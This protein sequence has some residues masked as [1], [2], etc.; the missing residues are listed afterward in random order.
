MPRVAVLTPQQFGLLQTLRAT[1]G[2]VAELL[3]GFPAEARHWSPLPEDWTAPQVVTH[4]AAADALFEQRFRRILGE[5]NPTVAYFD[6]EQ[7]PPDGNARPAD[8]LVR[9]AASRQSLLDL[10]SPLPPAAWD[11]P[12]VHSRSGPTTLGRQVLAVAEHDREHLAQLAAL[13]TAWDQHQPS[14]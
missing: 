6:A 11:R 7:A 10:L 3:A 4:L 9:F 13:R 8:A 12:A 2:R 14:A 5:R 1:P